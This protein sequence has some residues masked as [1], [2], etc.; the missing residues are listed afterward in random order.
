MLWPGS[1]EGLVQQHSWFFLFV[2]FFERQRDFKAGDIL[3]QTKE[4][5]TDEPSSFP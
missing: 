1:W 4:G 5:R 2:F 3:Q